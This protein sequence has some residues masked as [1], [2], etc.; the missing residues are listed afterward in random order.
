LN[1]VAPFATR[2]WTQ[3]IERYESILIDTSGSI[4][5]GGT[6]SELFREYL[7]STKKL[8]L[9]EPA[10]T[11]VWVSSI[12]TDSFGGVHEVMKGWT[13]GAHGIFTDD[14]NCARRELAS[15]FEIRSS[16]M[17]PVASGTDL[18]GSLW[19]LKHS[20]SQLRKLARPHEVS[21]TIWVFPDMINETKNF[22]MQD[23]MKMAMVVQESI[24]RRIRM[25]RLPRSKYCSQH[26][27][28]RL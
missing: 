8:L 23:L 9:T 21:K 26:S 11:Q 10:N 24:F 7:T 12:S 18:F 25:R 15:N 22:P 17:A 19:H 14:L 4:S 20:S 1:L 28:S 27:A 6:S 16:G 3:N 13:H 2:A 5:R